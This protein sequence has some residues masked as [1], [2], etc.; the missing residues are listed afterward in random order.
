MVPIHVI[1]KKGQIR[2]DYSGSGFDQVR[3]FHFRQECFSVLVFTPYELYL[4]IVQ[5]G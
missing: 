4:V 2:E 5:Y 1:G 3:K